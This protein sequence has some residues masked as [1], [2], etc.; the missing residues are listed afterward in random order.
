MVQII[1]VF[2]SYL[3]FFLH[4]VNLAYVLKIDFYIHF[5]IT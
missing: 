1:L 4:L 2:F 5:F 3:F